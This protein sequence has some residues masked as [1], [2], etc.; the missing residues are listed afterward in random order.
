M[1]GFYM[2]TTLLFNELKQF[3]ILDEPLKCVKPSFLKIILAFLL[4]NIFDL[5]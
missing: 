1:T 3:V 4:A 5:S 2:M